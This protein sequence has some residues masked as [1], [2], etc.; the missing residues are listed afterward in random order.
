MHRGKGKREALNKILGDSRE[1]PAGV[2]IQQGKTEERGSIR[3]EC[4]P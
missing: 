4:Y 2:A 1:D 3:L